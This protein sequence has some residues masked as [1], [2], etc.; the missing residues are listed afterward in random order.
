MLFAG[1]R[2]CTAVEL[3][4][5]LSSEGVADERDDVLVGRKLLSPAERWLR[6]GCWLV[7]GSRSGIERI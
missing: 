6:D 3:K 4:R 1:K 7:T 5:N 2:S